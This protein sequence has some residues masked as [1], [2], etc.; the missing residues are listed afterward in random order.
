[1]LGLS[2]HLVSLVIRAIPVLLV[3]RERLVQRV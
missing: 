2:V 1:M 3:L